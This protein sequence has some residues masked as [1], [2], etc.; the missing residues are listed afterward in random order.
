MQFT[1]EEYSKV[2]EEA[3]GIYTEF[4][5]VK[6][7]ALNFELVHFTSEGFN[8]ITYRAGSHSRSEQDQYMRLKMLELARRVIQISATFQ[9]YE[10]KLQDVVARVGKKKVKV[11]KL[12]KYWGFIA[13]QQ[14]R[15]IKVIIRQTGEGKI[16]FWSVVP[17]WR[18]TRHGDL[19]FRNFATGNLLED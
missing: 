1:E 13:I 5:P 9:E 15:K 6:C 10:E 17:F 2:K 14:K 3:R 12:I 4:K 7:P 16:H 18:T 11:T 19:V 8:H